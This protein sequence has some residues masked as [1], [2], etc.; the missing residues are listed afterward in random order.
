MLHL[1]Q[2]SW[3]ISLNTSLI[4]LALNLVID[5]FKE[6]FDYACWFLSRGAHNVEW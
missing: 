1:D 2:I 5:T 4:L 3:I 6:S